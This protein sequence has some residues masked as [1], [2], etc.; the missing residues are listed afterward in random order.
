LA[1]TRWGRTGLAEKRHRHLDALLRVEALGGDGRQGD[2]APEA[3][4]RF[5]VALRH[6]GVDGIAAG[7]GEEGGE[8]Q[9]EHEASG[10]GGAAGEEMVSRPAGADQ[11]RPPDPP[12][13]GAGSD[14]SFVEAGRWRR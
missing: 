8:D 13:G 6:F 3:L 9:G 4:D 7:G 14:Y 5:A 10:R 1:T 2:P 12:D 11:T